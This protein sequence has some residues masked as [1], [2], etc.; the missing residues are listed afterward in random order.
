MIGLP[1]G[2]RPEEAAATAGKL[3]HT[4]PNPKKYSKLGGYIVNAAWI[5][6]SVLKGYDVIDIGPDPKKVASGKGNAIWYT[7]ERIITGALM[8]RG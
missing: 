6:A 2:G 7:T 3:A 5:V 1:D 8:R 4:V